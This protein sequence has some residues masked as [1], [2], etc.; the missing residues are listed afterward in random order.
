MQFVLNAQKLQQN[1]SNVLAR[2][3]EEAV[4]NARR[5]VNDIAHNQWIDLAASK[6]CAKIFAG[7]CIAPLPSHS[8]TQYVTALAAVRN[9][10][11]DDLVVFFGQ[12]IGITI[13]RR[14]RW[15]L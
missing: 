4:W 7:R 12:T 11:I 2:W 14:K 3:H 8:P 15:S 9:H 6:C 10:D 5:N 1:V 13:K